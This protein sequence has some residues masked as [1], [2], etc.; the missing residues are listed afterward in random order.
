[1]TLHVCLLFVKEG[2]NRPDPTPGTH[3]RPPFRYYYFTI[4]FINPIVYVVTTVTALHRPAKR[5]TVDDRVI[6][7]VTSVGRNRRWCRTVVVTYYRGTCVPGCRRTVVEYRPTRFHRS[8]T[9]VPYR[10]KFQTFI[11]VQTRTPIFSMPMRIVYYNLCV[12]N[13][14]YMYRSSVAGIV[15]WGRGLS[16]NYTHCF[17]TFL[18][19]VAP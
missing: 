5:R 4:P 14:M 10:S 13:G 9:P 1:M 3:I 7:A 12:I 6:I 11:V 18:A 16:I 19:R 2:K 15:E 8:T 17:Q